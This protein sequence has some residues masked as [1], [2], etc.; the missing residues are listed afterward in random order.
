MFSRRNIVLGS[1]ALA[2]A[3][4][5]ASSRATAAPPKIPLAA[6]PLTAFLARLARNAPNQVLPPNKYQSEISGALSE[7]SGQ[8]EKLTAH[9]EQLPQIL[10]GLVRINFHEEAAVLRAFK[11]Q[12]DAVVAG[13]GAAAG[14]IGDDQRARLKQMVADLQIAADHIWQYGSGA[15]PAA[16]SANALVLTIHRLLGSPAAEIAG[17]VDDQTR[18]NFAKSLDPGVSRSLVDFKG[19]QDRAARELRILL[20]SY[21]R[22]GTLAFTTTGAWQG[23]PSGAANYQRCYPVVARL[24]PAAGLPNTKFTIKRERINP[25]AIPPPIF[26]DMGRAAACTS[27]EPRREDFDVRITLRLNKQLG[28]MQQREWYAQSFADL[29]TDVQGVMAAL[30]KSVG[31]PDTALWFARSAEEINNLDR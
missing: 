23:R 10:D 16:A 21:P 24:E 5:S 15:Y 13:A 20:V 14:D 19:R 22:Y 4:S 30:R 9:I 29:A 12:V 7:M 2:V 25:A 31:L 8:F 18:L 26:P 3:A 11:P 1:A 27:G 17:M 28:I 6:Q